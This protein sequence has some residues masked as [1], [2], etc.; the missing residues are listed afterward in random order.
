MRAVRLP[1]DRLLC[2]L[3]GSN[4]V[5]LL[6]SLGLASLGA[7]LGGCIVESQCHADYDCATDERCSARG[8]C[9]VECRQDSDCWPNKVYDGKHCV[10]HR[11]EFSFDERIAAPSFCLEVA[12]PASGLAGQELCLSSTRGKV[13][14]LYFGWIT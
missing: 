2:R 9:Y 8:A 10:A 1:L 13:V 14:L 4:R 5:R 7:L 6:L 3:Q 12:N 11:C